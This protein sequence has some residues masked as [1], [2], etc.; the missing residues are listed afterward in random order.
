M[1]NILYNSCVF[2]EVIINGE[3]KESRPKGECKVRQVLM[4][5]YCF[6]DTCFVRN[7]QAFCFSPRKDDEDRWENSHEH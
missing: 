1:K 4:W 6:V 2:F 5:D 7:I 3:D